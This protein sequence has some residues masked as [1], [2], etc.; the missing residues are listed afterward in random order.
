[1]TP[2]EIQAQREE[3]MRRYETARTVPHAVHSLPMDNFLS[4][5]E[6]LTV[7]SSNVAWFEYNPEK[8]ELTMGTTKGRIYLYRQISKFEAEEFVH[9][10][11]KGKKV[12]DSL[13][14]R[15][16]QHGTRK[17]FTRLA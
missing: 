17:P 16:T 6:R 1:M 8:G 11:S 7:E 5:R 12:W 13:R 10:S 9:A 4:G 2:E 3:R 15:G 14:V